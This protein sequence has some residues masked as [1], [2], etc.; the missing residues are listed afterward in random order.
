MLLK[1]VIKFQKALALAAAASNRHEAEAAELA[2]RRLMEEYDINP[3]EIPDASFC[4]HMNFADNALLKKLRD[5][6]RLRPEFIAA[7]NRRQNR[8]RGQQARRARESAARIEKLRGLFDDVNLG[9][10]E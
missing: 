1:T 6:W 3:I 4:N 10:T 5:E 9:L 7:E 8:S 2:A